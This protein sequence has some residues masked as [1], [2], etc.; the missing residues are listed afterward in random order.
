MRVL[1]TGGAGFIG[2]HLTEKLKT[3][4]HDV[5][6][7]DNMMNPCSAP[8]KSFVYGDVRYLDD[9]R[10]YIHNSDIVFHLAAQISVDKSIFNPQETIDINVGGTQNVLQLCK[11]YRTPMI[12]A[13]SSEIYGTSQEPFMS[14]SHP[15]DAQSPYAAS[16]VAGDRLCYSY[17]KT[18]DMDVRVLRN[19]N[20]AG[21][22]QNGYGAV[23]SSFIEKVLHDKSPE[24]FGDGTQERDYMAVDDAVD[25]YLTVMTNGYPGIVVNAGS[26]KTVTVN[27]IASKV[28]NYFHKDLKPVHTLARPGE[29]MRLCCDNLKIRGLG[30][31]PK[32]D[33]DY[34]IEQ[35]VNARF[36]LRQD[37]EIKYFVDGLYGRKHEDT[38]L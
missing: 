24:I 32:Y 27:E 12:F 6:S 10:S 33:V 9:L 8:D 30:W 21:P 18:Y 25:A 11:L 29:V 1:V 22:Y 19:F 7:L 28:I 4:G 16:K 38:V 13:S 5:I 37:K 20:T 15:L 35:M 23:F 17:Y 3:L 34:I 36:A 26:G 14:E 2:Y 31:K